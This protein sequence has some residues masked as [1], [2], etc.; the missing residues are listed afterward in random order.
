MGGG[1]S[2]LE[3]MG[4]DAVVETFFAVFCSGLYAVRLLGFNIQ[5]V[6]LYPWWKNLFFAIVGVCLGFLFILLILTPF[7]FAVWLSQDLLY[8][9]AAEVTFLGWTCVAGGIGYVVSIC[10]PLCF[11]DQMECGCDC[12]DGCC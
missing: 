11:A 9:T 8:L 12:G 3:I 5:K 1:L 2:I 10:M 7:W 6:L 4:N